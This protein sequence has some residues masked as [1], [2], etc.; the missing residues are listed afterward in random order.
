M[1]EIKND[2]SNYY[3][4]NNKINN[5]KYNVGYNN[6]NNIEN[7]SFDIISK[8]SDDNYN[9]NLK[10]IKKSNI[11]SPSFKRM[12]TKTSKEPY[13]FKTV[14][15]NYGIISSIKINASYFLSEYLI[16]IWFEK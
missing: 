15:N 4:E 13:I 7:K 3:S 1:N 10:N 9:Y 8:K 2:I 14:K 6:E 5:N 12:K 16:P 11:K